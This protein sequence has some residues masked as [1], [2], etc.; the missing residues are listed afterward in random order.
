[1][2]L[3]KAHTIGKRKPLRTSTELAA[4]FDITRHKLSRLLKTTNG[5]KPIMKLVN[6]HTQTNTWYDPAEVRTWWVNLSDSL[7]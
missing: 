2:H 4:E 6:P 5:P 3:D 7:K 1:M